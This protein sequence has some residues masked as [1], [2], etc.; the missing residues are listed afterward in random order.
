MATNLTKFQ[1]RVVAQ[2]TQ[3]DNSFAKTNTST[4][5]IDVVGHSLAWAIG[6][7]SANSVNTSFAPVAYTLA[8]GNTTTIDLS[9][10][11]ANK[12]PTGS[13]LALSRIKF[14]AV[15]AAYTNGHVNGVLVNGLV[16]NSA[17]L[18]TVWKFEAGGGTVWWSPSVN[19]TLINSTSKLLTLT[20]VDASNSVNVTVVVVGSNA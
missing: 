13:A 7:N 10:G 20:N 6:A 3:I 18:N 5:L 9:N 12:T 16:A 1:T 14:V 8:G 2:I 19:G 15:T 11:T 4:G 17:L